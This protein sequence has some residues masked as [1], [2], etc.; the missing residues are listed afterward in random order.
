MTACRADGSRR[1][2]EQDTMAK[3]GK[4]NPIKVL[5]SVRGAVAA[6]PS[7][8][9][10][11]KTAHGEKTVGVVFSN[12]SEHA[13][14]VILRALN[15]TLSPEGYTLKVK[16]AFNSQTK[17][18]RI[19][20][21]FIDAKVEGLIIEP[22]KSQMLCKHM[23]VYR[24]LDRRGI[25][26]IFIRSNYPQMIDHPRLVMDDSQGAYLVTRHL[27]ATGRKRII[28]LFKTDDANGY[29]RHSG[30]VRA[31]Q[32][33]GRSYMPELVIWFHSEDRF[34]K[35]ALMLDRILKQYPKCDAVVCYSDAMAMAIIRY[36]EGKGYSVPE[37]IAVTG[38]GDY[39][40]S[41]PGKTGLTSVELPY[42]A[43]GS[44]AG[45]MLMELMLGASVEEELGEIVLE[46][47]LVIRGSSVR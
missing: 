15:E 28:G 40:G 27:I 3:S 6:L 44:G 4:N 16:D 26:Y 35:P 24:Q 30:Y 34:K 45:D 21:E 12:I 23:D 9:R 13:A 39:A 43:L 47:E 46:P 20:K 42:R 8:V 10:K 22:S 31:I 17:E 32:E 25:P 41:L 7:V 2:I 38:Y 14:P 5:T 1:L 37:D 19:L 36:L 11:K 29:E 18:E 33:V